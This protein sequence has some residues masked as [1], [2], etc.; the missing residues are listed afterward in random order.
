MTHSKRE[1]EGVAME[2]S[3]HSMPWA[4]DLEAF[5]VATE[6]GLPNLAE[7]EHRLRG[8]LHAR[9]V[10]LRRVVV[11]GGI[12]AACG[13]ALGAPQL[14]E[15]VANTD[16]SRRDASSPGETVQPRTEA[17]LHR[18]A[19]RQQIVGRGSTT[20]PA[21]SATPAQPPAV[22]ESDSPGFENKLGPGRQALVDFLNREYEPLVT[23]CVEQAAARAPELRG[24]YRLNIGTLADEE[25]GAVV[26][27]AEPGVGSEVTD[28]EFF[29]CLRESAYTLV[30]PPPLTTGQEAF[31]MNG[32]FGAPPSDEDAPTP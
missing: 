2:D 3:M 6:A 5:R 12:V 13:T 21:R 9:S 23:D 26:D 7:T 20:T 10:T 8:K 31:E 32:Y 4:Q 1:Q 22:A 15:R 28:P 11:M 24:M 29:E 30:I 27:V 17:R 18:D 25:L 14:F 19:L 16:V